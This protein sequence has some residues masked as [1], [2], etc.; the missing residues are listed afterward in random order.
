MT[1]HSSVVNS[2]VADF[3]YHTSFALWESV[4]VPNRTDYFLNKCFLSP[5]PFFFLL[6]CLH[7]AEDTAV[8]GASQLASSAL[9]QSPRALTWSHIVVSGSVP[10]S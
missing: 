10:P 1:L 9:L 3:S 4:L 2:E 7:R 6:T 8:L 5:P